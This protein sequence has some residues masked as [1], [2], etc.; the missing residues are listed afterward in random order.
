MYI[1]SISSNTL[2]VERGVAGSTAAT[3]SSSD[4]VYFYTYPAAVTQACLDL[5]RLA[6]IDR[7][8][9]LQDEVTVGGATISTVQ[10]ERR[11]VLHGIDSYAT[12][13]ANMGVTF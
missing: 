7:T 5:T 6:W 13:T 8:G 1:E 4:Q 10:D 2:T 3:H 11:T 12:H 9:G